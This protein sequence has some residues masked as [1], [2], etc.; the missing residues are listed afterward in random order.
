MYKKFNAFYKS[1][2][3]IPKGLKIKCLTNDENEF[4]KH[5]LRIRRMI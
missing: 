2:E 5:L 3:N 1:I 4:S